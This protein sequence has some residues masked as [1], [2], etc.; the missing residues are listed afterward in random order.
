[1]KPAVAARDII[2]D[3]QVGD[4]INVMRVVRQCFIARV[5]LG[6]VPATG[7]SEPIV[8]ARSVLTLAEVTGPLAGR[9]RQG[10]V[11]RLQNH[12]LRHSGR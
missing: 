5:R 10:L 12:I 11:P 4:L 9:V 6:L 8:D 1:V 2:A 7:R 3:A